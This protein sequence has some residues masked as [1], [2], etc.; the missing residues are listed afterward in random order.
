MKRYG[1]DLACRS[2]GAHLA[3]PCDA[4][5]DELRRARET[6]WRT[7]GP[8][9]ER[10]SRAIVAARAAGAPWRAVARATDL[11]PLTLRRLAHGKRG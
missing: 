4:W 11:N 9:R 1:D 5:C 8:A 10:L 2:C 7:H 6:A 3:A